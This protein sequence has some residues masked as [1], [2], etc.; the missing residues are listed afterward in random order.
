MND[1]EKSFNEALEGKDFE[2][3]YHGI[4]F[5]CENILKKLLTGFPKRLDFDEIVDEASLKCFGSLK[6]HLKKDPNYKVEKLVNFCSTIIN[7]N[8]LRSKCTGQTFSE[9][10]G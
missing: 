3:M 7:R 8:G 2:Q 5:C 6:E 1:L 9:K 10:I 4:H